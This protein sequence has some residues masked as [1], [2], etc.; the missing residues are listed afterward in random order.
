[1]HDI[2]FFSILNNLIIISENN[3]IEL[4][5]NYFSQ[6]TMIG[7]ASLILPFCLR[8]I[9]RYLKYRPDSDL[10]LLALLVVKSL[11]CWDNKEFYLSYLVLC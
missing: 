11:S 1:M 3:F 4:A 8:I 10:L 9:A 2:C 5:K 6:K 7:I